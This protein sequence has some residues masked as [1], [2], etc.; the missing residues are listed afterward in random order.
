MVAF[1]SIFVLLAL[2]TEALAAT[3]SLICATDVGTETVKN[4]P[5]TTLTTVK[6]VTVVKEIIRK[7][8]VVVI[9]VAKT[10]TSWTTEFTLST[11]TAEPEIETETMTTFAQNIQTIY[12]TNV[13]TTTSTTT[14]ASTNY[15]TLTEARMASFTGIQ[16]D[17]LKVKERAVKKAANVQLLSAKTVVLYPQRVR[18]SKEI[19][20]Y[21]TK[22]VTTTVQGPRTT[23]KP[24]T[25]TITSTTVSTIVTTECPDCVTTETETEEQT[26]TTMRV[27][28][29]LSTLAQTVTV[30]MRVPQATVYAACDS[31]NILLTDNN[32]GRVVG[33][34]DATSDTMPTVLGDNYTAASCCAE[35]AKR[36]NCRVS[37]LG[38]IAGLSSTK[39]STCSLFLATD[40]S[41]CANGKQPVFAKYVTSN[42]SPAQP[43]YVYSN[44]PCGQLT[45]GGDIGSN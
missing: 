1:K 15:L 31:S 7:V 20:S 36:P 37:L 19:P 42:T 30:E 26:I 14:T 18:C 10:T 8:N 16:D 27:I 45:N 13:V 29:Q 12:R 35:C 21:T 34:T 3:P 23:L 39:A 17:S 38:Q 32:G 40:V 11:F 9:P 44:G 24:K 25:K 4:V 5:T 6:H 41:K 28:Q 43:R 33:I 2:S 22:V